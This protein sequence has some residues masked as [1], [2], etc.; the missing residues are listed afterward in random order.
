MM[1]RTIAFSY[2]AERKPDGFD[3]IAGSLLGKVD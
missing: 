1:H 3:V 2:L